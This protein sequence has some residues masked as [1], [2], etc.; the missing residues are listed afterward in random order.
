[1]EEYNEIPDDIAHMAEALIH[2]ERLSQTKRTKQYQIIVS[3]IEK[4]LH[5]NCKHLEI[6]E[7][8]IDI[9]PEKSMK[10]KYCNHCGLT[11]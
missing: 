8:Y 11:M 2:I 7:D 6:I 5:D 4:Y 10:I 1:M 9:D 3:S